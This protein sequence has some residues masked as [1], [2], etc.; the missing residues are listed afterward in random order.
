MTARKLNLQTIASV[1]RLASGGIKNKKTIAAAINVAPGTFSKWLKRGNSS[2][3]PK[4]RLTSFL[5][6]ENET[7]AIKAYQENP[8]QLYRDLVNWY[9]RGLKEYESK[10]YR[11]DEKIK[12]IYQDF[13]GNIDVMPLFYE[14][15]DYEDE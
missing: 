5:Y 11:L 1:Y 8:E 7:D 12:L 2:Q 6:Y 14:D 13:D 9:E 15:D 10:R 3:S 4:G